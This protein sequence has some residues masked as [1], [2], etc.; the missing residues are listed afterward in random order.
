MSVDGK[1]YYLKSQGINLFDRLSAKCVKIIIELN[2]LLSSFL[3]RFIMF[4]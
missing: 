1:T 3:L 4:L 2:E